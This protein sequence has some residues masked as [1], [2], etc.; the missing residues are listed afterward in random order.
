MFSSR[1]ALILVSKLSVVVCWLVSGQGGLTD[2]YAWVKIER[3]RI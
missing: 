1:S 3:F 2:D